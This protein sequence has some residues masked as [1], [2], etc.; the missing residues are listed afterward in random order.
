M[1]RFVEIDAVYKGLDC[2]DSTERAPVL[3][4]DRRR[5]IHGASRS[6]LKGKRLGESE[7]KFCSRDSCTWLFASCK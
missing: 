1:D 7:I 4:L 3:D 5:L 6:K 2:G